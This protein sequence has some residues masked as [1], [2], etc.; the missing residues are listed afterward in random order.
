MMVLKLK[1]KIILNGELIVGIVL[2]MVG[3]IVQNLILG[4]I[5]GNY[6]NINI[7]IIYTY[8]VYCSLLMHNFIL[9]FFY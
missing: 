8:I 5:I 9:I 7:Y 1:M 2:R 4:I 3:N 6:N